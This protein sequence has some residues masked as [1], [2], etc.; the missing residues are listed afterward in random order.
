MYKINSLIM[1]A[2][3]IGSVLSTY[4]AFAE[5]NPRSL[6][7]DKRIKIIPYNPNDITLLRTS[8]GY[9][10]EIVFNSDETVEKVSNPDGL[11]WQVVPANN[12]IFIKPMSIS[13]TNMTILTNKHDYNFQLESYSY[14]P[15]NNQ[16][17]RVQFVYPEL[18]ETV[19]ITNFIPCKSGT[20]QSCNYKYS[21]TGDKDT[22]PIQAFDN[23]KFTYFKFATNRNSLVPSIF[24][25]DKERNESPVNYH[26][27]NNYIVV[28]SIAKQFT[29]R[30]GNYVTSI[31]NDKAIGDWS[32]VR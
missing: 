9:Q 18:D 15:P 3:F 27:V 5:Q 7:T 31:Y 25:V 24:A 32:A 30:R 22:A 8:L 12:Y 19:T 10:V 13:K 14:L 26:I 6:P 29:F 20:S 17:Y 28:N 23:D 21:Y 2:L 1:A 4:P 16:T 11:V